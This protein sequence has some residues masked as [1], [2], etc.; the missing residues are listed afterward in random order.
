MASVTVF[1]DDAVRGTLPHV[2]A[3]EGTPTADRLRI[4]SDVGDPTG[5]G[6]GWLLL[7]L[8]P[9]G[10]LGLALMATAR[11]RTGEHLVVEVPYGEPSYQRLLRARRVRQRAVAAAVLLAVAT[12]FLA[13]SAEGAW[14]ALPAVGLVVSVVAV[15][16][17]DARLN[18]LRVG[19][20]LDA[21]RRWVEL[22]R[23]HPAFALA[24]EEQLRDRDVRRSPHT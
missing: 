5:L 6:V 13:T 19:V 3:K 10:W 9:V 16:R 2:C 23:V 11:V 12:I 15:L 21:S 4:H 14:W 18:D 1:V 22:A 8:G 20:R 7:L 24:C 17:A